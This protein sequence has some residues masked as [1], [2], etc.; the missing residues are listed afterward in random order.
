MC[1]ACAADSDSFRL[2]ID[3][4]TLRD[5]LVPTNGQTI[6]GCDLLGGDSGRPGPRIA[7]Y[8]HD[9][10]G[11]GHVRR[12]LLLAQSMLRAF[13]RASVLA[14]AGAR[15]AARFEAVEGIDFLTLPALLKHGDGSYGSRDLRLPLREIV[16]LRRRT[17]EAALL[18]FRPDVLVVD[19]V[20]RGAEGELESVL[21]QLADAG[22]TRLVLGLRDVLD[23]PA[24][25]AA[26]WARDRS[27]DF[28]DDVFH[29]LWIYG[30]RRVCDPIQEY[31][32]P[33]SIASRVRFTGYLDQTRRLEGVSRESRREVE[34]LVA[35]NQRLAVCLVGGGQDGSAL[36]S[37]FASARMPEGTLGIVV[38]GPFMPR[39]ARDEVARRVADRPDMRLLDFLGEADLL[40]A[41]ADRVV[42]MGGYNT[43][44]S[45]LSFAKQALIIPRV[46][47]RLE[48]FIRASR[49]AEMNLLEMLHPDQLTSARLTQ[50]LDGPPATCACPRR[51]L[52]MR[53][54]ERVPRFVLD[55][56]QRR[57][58]IPGRETPRSHSAVTPR[59]DR[60]RTKEPL[61]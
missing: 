38:A 5:A 27:L 58:R 16:A 59:H 17:L 1:E 33:A 22:D 6:P 45:I 60:S 3:P 49:L 51:L 40:V 14:I 56:L 29:E 11:V 46:R 20:P 61:P 25:V 57:D 48:Q 53:G 24:S 12:N 41:R 32:L 43:V 52:D 55:V 9:T 37:A 26:D 8:S 36:A 10:M 4:T 39:E 19:K 18:G 50:W 28:I 35:S 15:E 31:D 44:A 13:P 21:R 23:D 47:P 7:F 54:L 42:A 34:S 30:D 2:R